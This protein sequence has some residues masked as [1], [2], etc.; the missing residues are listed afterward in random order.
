MK[1]ITKTATKKTEE[2]YAVVDDGTK[3]IPIYNTAH[4]LICT[5]H[6]RPNDLDLYN[7]YDNFIKHDFAEIIAPL[8]E[9]DIERDGTATRD[10]DIKALNDASQRL[11]AGIN[12]MLDSDDAGDIFKTRNPF[13]SVNGKF[14]SAHVLDALGKIVEQVT[15]EEVRLSNERMAKFLPPAT[16]ADE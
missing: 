3:A 14:F 16:P 13:S 5:I 12:K 11:V 15:E 4:Q 10:E 6:I 9:L 1:A 2:L 7:R 8:K